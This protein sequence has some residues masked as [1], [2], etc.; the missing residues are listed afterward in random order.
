MPATRRTRKTTQRY[1]PLVQNPSDSDRKKIESVKPKDEK[2]ARKTKSNVTAPSAQP[3]STV[4]PPQKK[5]DQASAP[6]QST[7]LQNRPIAPQNLLPESSSSDPKMVF[8][9]DKEGRGIHVLEIEYP[10]N[11]ALDFPIELEEHDLRFKNGDII[12][13]KENSFVF[14]VAKKRQNKGAKLSLKKIVFDTNF[15]TTKRTS[16]KISFTFSPG[17][18]SIH[19]SIVHEAAFDAVVKRFGF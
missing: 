8:H 1:S 9:Q 3:S 2:E 15:E 14:F 6:L 13:M 10:P 11:S 16:W 17:V 12:L 7:P 5:E 4:I 19:P 18:A